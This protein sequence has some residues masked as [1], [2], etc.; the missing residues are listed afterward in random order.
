M[1]TRNSAWSSVS[2]LDELNA[3]AASAAS[4]NVPFG[5]YVLGFG[6]SNQS[7][8]R[9]AEMNLGEALADRS[10]EPD[11]IIIASWDTYPTLVASESDPASLSHVRLAAELLLP[12]YQ[13]GSITGEDPSGVG[14]AVAGTGEPAPSDDGTS[15]VGIQLEGSPEAEGSFALIVSST[16]G[17]LSVPNTSGAAVAG[18]G[19]GTILLSGDIGEIDNALASLT[20]SG[21]P[22]QAT[23][24][25]ASS[26]RST[27]TLGRHPNRFRYNDVR[28]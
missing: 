18:S 11:Q 25:D 6:S 10:I 2:G 1:L 26:L 13:G 5:V 24:I 21:T 3:F 23:M 4:V 7:W 14:I 27:R 12:L 15:I 22:S 16:A 28:R 8:V 19:T 9:S 17:S 20:A